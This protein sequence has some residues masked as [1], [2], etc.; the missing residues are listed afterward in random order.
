MNPIVVAV[1]VLA[2]IGISSGL[3]LYYIAEKFKV[4]EDPRI[5]EIEEVLP[6]GN[7]GACGYPGCRQFAEAVAMADSLDGYFCPVGGNDVMAEI[8]QILGVEVVEHEKELAVVRCAGSSEFRPLTNE[9]DGPSSCALEHALYSGHTECQYG[10]L[11]HGDCVAACEFDAIYMDPVTDLPVVVE[12]KCTACGA[13]VEACPRDIIELRPVGKKSRRIYVACVSEEKAGLTSK[14]CKVGCIGCGN[15]EKACEFD[16]IT[17]EN[18]LSYI[19]PA[20]CRLCR[21][22]VSVCPTESI[23]ELNF[24]VRRSIPSNKVKPKKK[25]T[26]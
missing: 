8:A 26:A 1:V 6:G 11:G 25:P 7:C 21:A 13:C 16:A 20:K 24:P 12:D 22:C 18:N 10:C 23:W 19:D 17:I 15:C 5:D 4:D 14:A 3:I 9:Y 2:V